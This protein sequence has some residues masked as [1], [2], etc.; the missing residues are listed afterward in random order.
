MGSDQFLLAFAFGHLRHRLTHLVHEADHLFVP[1]LIQVV[2][3]V[4]LV[5]V[6]EALVQIRFLAS[7]N[8]VQDVVLVLYLGF[9][10][11]DFELLF[12]QP[13]FCLSVPMLVARSLLL[14]LYCGEMLALSLQLA[15]FRSSQG[16]EH[17][18]LLFLINDFGPHRQVT[19]RLSPEHS[20]DFLRVHLQLVQVVILGALDQEF[21]ER[22]S[23]R[24]FV[25]LVMGVVHVV[26][27]PEASIEDHKILALFEE[28][29]RQQLHR[30]LGHF[31]DERANEGEALD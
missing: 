7:N 10:I 9:L 25:Q 11:D 23:F 16:I 13:F 19:E 22:P 14:A 6:F 24:E 27:Q 17:I 2:E 26:A 1:F 21:L 31:F 12:L 5:S 8:H 4:A 20:E 28:S 3:V 18:F 30:Y 29:H 15:L